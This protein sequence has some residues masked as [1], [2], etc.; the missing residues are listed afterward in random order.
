MPGWKRDVGRRRDALIE[1]TIPHVRR[2]VRWNSPSYGVEGQGWFLS[3][4]CFTRYVK[5]TFLCGSDLSPLPPIGP[6]IRSR[7]TVICTKTRRSTKE[8]LANWLRQAEKRPGD[9]LFSLA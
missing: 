3:L 7:A 5:V 6:S 9:P 2:A 8:H 4:H 1:Q